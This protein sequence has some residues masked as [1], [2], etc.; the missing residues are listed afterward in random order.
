MQKASYISLYSAY[1]LYSAGNPDL[2]G[3]RLNMEI[4]FPVR[5]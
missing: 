5:K 3:V 4:F 2:K 1:K